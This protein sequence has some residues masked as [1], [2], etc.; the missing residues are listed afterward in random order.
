MTLHYNDDQK[1]AMIEAYMPLIE[2]LPDEKD[3]RNDFIHKLEQGHDF[4]S[5]FNLLII[6]SYSET[7]PFSEK[8][9]KLIRTFNSIQNNQ[10]KPT[11]QLILPITYDKT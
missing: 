5:D 11:P 6:Q 9:T 10:P 4:S 8:L 1:E 3:K 7:S 2:N